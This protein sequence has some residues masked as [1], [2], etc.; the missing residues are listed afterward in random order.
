MERISALGHFDKHFEWYNSNKILT[1]L[2]SK[3]GFISLSG[4]FSIPF[5][6]DEIEL[7]KDGCFNVRIDKS[8]GVMTIDGYE[9]IPVKYSEKIADNF[10]NLI[11]QDSISGGLGILNEH[12]KECIPTLYEHLQITDNQN[13][14]FLDMVVMKTTTIIFSVQF[15]MLHGDVSGM[16]ERY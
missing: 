5:K 3:Y 12:G 10:K 13:I 4:F 16:M 7:R 1:Q 14:V 11:V 6:Y 15:R 2:G 9:F 8:W